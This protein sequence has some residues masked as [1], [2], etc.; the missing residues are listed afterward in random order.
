MEQR[1]YGTHKKVGLNT[2]FKLIL[3]I[4]NLADKEIISSVEGLRSL[5]IFGNVV[6]M[7]AWRRK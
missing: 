5:L 1:K 3:I 7:T 4:L 2:L 6:F